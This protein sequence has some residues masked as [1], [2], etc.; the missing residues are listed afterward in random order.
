MKQSK[1]LSNAETGRAGEQIVC[2]YLLQ[3][4]CRIIQ[5]QWRCRWGEV[6]IIACRPQGLHFVEVKTRSNR[7]WDADGALAV[8]PSKQRKLIRTAQLFLQRHP[9]L[10]DQPCR[11]DVALVCKGDRG[12]FQLTRY[13][14][15]AFQMG[16]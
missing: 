10:V 14:P 15:A 8:S 1:R 2:D 7:N 6:D 3:Q 12:L 13:I 11:F 5:R 4:G 16:A 9:K